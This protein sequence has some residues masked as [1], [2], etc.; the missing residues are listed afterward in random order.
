MSSAFNTA[1]YLNFLVFH[2][3]LTFQIQVKY[4]HITS[5]GL[6]SIMG[7]VLVMAVLF[8]IIRSAMKGG[9]GMNTF[10]QMSK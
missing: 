2:G 8:Y 7:T 10:S 3:H 9:G 4:K 5:D 1:I 6:S